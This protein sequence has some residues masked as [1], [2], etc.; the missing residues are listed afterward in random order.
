MREKLVNVC[1]CDFLT[2]VEFRSC[3]RAQ[4]EATSARNTNRPV[5]EEPAACAAHLVHRL[6]VG[7]DYRVI[8]VIQYIDLSPYYAGWKSETTFLNM[9]I[10][11]VSLILL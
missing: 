8:P 7:C 5:N 4:G 11:L 9:E 2:T 1:V 3:S 6:T 10:I